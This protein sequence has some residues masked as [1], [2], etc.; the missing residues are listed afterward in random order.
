[1]LDDHTLQFGRSRL[2]LGRVLQL[3]DPSQLETV[4]LIM[5]YARRRYLDDM[6]PVHE[7]LDLIDRDLST[8]GLDCLSDD[9]RHDLARPRRYELSAA[10]NRLPSLRIM[11]VE[12]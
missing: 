6:R 8:E 9:L 4:G 3:A 7:L 11:R 2:D 1:M 10:L 5:D 12:S